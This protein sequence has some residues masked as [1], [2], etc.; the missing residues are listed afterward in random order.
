MDAVYENQDTPS[1]VVKYLHLFKVRKT[2]E[3]DFIRVAVRILKRVKWKR[4]VD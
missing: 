1:E 4:P 3:I 2:E